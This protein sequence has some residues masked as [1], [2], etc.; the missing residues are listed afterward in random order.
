[1]GEHEKRGRGKKSFPANG[2][3]SHMTKN[4]PR[5]SLTLTFPTSGEYFQVL[6]QRQGFITLSVNCAV[7]KQN[8]IYLIRDTAGCSLGGWVA[9]D[10]LTLSLTHIE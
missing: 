9:A 6:I 8:N 3:I 1:M 7:L 2:R 10:K 5:W 4:I